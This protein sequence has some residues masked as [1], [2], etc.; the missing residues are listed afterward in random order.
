M[1]VNFIFGDIATLRVDAVVS[2]INNELQYGGSVNRAIHEAAGPELMEYYRKT[3]RCPTGAAKLTPGFNLPARFIIHTVAPVW[4][5]GTE[6]E[7]KWLASC[8]QRSLGLAV[9]NQCRTVA[10]PVFSAHSTDFPYEKAL[11][12]A[13]DTC[14][15]YLT[16]KHIPLDIYLV[17]YGGMQNNETDAAAAAPFSTVAEYVKSQ[18]QLDEKTKE[19]LQIAQTV[20]PYFAEESYIREMTMPDGR[21][22]AIM[23]KGAGVRY[24]IRSVPTGPKKIPDRKEFTVEAPFTRK[25]LQYMDIKGMMAPVVY[26]NAGYDRKFFSKMQSD[27][28]YHPRKYTVVRFALALRLNLEETEDL[29]NAAGYALSRSMIVD[30]VVAYCISHDMRSVWEVNNILKSWGLDA[31]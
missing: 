27:P 18:Y 12:I 11:Q 10:I 8:Y 3:G 19:N 6:H 4:C 5:G 7:D 23:P 17:L 16:G 26:S 25:L 1:G 2:V 15:Y 22:V 14:Q 13:Y 20:K 9:Q 21:R 24:S 31:I 29:L 30:L 28:E